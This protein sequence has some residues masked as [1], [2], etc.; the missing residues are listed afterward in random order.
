MAF[1]VHRPRRLRRSALVRDLVAETRLSAEHLVWPLFVRNGTNVARPISSMPGVSQL[2]VDRLVDEVSRAADVGI[3]SVLLFGI[4][5]SKDATGSSASRDDGPVP[6]A[7]RAIKEKKLP[8]VVITDVCLCEYTDHGHCG[9]I[10]PAG[11]VD[12][13]STLEVLAS[14]ALSHARAGA[15]WVAPSDMMDGR[16]AAIRRALDANG[17]ANVAILSYAA[18]F[19][20]SFY[21][22]FREAAESKPQFG[23]RRS[24][25]MDSRNAREAL[26]EIRLDVEE[27]ADLVMVKPALA[28]LDV[29][30][31]A[32]EAFDVPL[33]AYNV[34][35][36]MSLVEAAAE[37]GW[38]DRR[39]MILEILGSIR[40]AG[41]DLVC[42]YWAREVA[43]W[44]AG[45]AR[46]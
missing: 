11:E 22:P 40:R 32:R 10:T 46:K 25:Q 28:Y 24:Y 19:A 9:M 14:Q 30:R 44:L 20:S 8:I 35:G 5:D 39:L 45:A 17:F 27:G 4:P 13:D 3:K 18:K 31:A 23:D 34:S 12:N 38:V 29:I 43:G 37:K 26:R 41:A 21:A 16:V 1:P 15:D 42:T 33:V 6:S 2:S 7:V 36:E